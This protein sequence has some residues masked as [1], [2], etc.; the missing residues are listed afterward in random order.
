MEL[1]ESCHVVVRELSCSCS[2]VA[3]ELFES[4]HGVV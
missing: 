2:R 4:C 3:M 1:F